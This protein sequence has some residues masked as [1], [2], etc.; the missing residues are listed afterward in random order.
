MSSAS[1]T[2][3][4]APTGL[5]NFLSLSTNGTT[6]RNSSPPSR[7]DDGKLDLA[8]TEQNFVDFTPGGAF[9]LSYVTVYPGN[10]DGTFQN[11]R[12]YN[13]DSDPVNVIASD[14]YGDGRPALL[15]AN[16]N[17]RT[18]SVL[19]SDVPGFY[20]AAPITL[21][22]HSEGIVTADFNHDGIMDMAV[23]NDPTCKAPCNGTVTVF[24]GTGHG[25]FGAGTSYT[26]GMHGSGIAAGDLNGD[27]VLDLVV[28]NNTAGDN[29]DVS[30]LLGNANGT[31]QVAHNFTLGVASSDVFL[32]D[33]NRDKKL[34]L[35]TVGGIALGTGAGSFGSLLPYTVLGS[36]AVVTHIAVADFNQ[37]GI[38]D[39]AAISLSN[40]TREALI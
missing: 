16:A 8:L 19:R 10:G 26:I 36:G 5:D 6:S 38:L 9:D 32:V 35:V 22:P 30:V 3:G 14:I 4:G 11:P 29:A 20:V 2:C 28:T 17:T 27:G 31:F 24:F 37:D 1:D 18:V 23:V 21:S 34:D 40:S 7:L 12:T 25:W 33:M 13:T 15:T 39:V